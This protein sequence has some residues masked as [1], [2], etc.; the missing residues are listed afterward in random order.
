MTDGTHS[1]VGAAVSAPD[2]G[3]PRALLFHG[4]AGTPLEVAPVA[5]ALKAGGIAAHTPLLPGHGTTPEAYLASSFGEWR[6]F[7][8]A[9]YRRLVAEGPLLLGGY[10][11]GGILALDIAENAAEA[12]LPA[13]A[14]LL[15]LATPLWFGAWRP[16]LRLRGP[17]SW[18]FRLLPLTARLW[19]VLRVPPRSAEARSVAPWQGH[20]EVA[21]LR[22]FA[23][24]D[25][26]LKSIRRRLGLV[27]APLCVIQLRHD[28]SCPPGHAA[29]LLTHCVSAEA[30]LH[31]LRT[32]SPHGGHLPT[33]HAESRER[34][35]QLARA[36]A[37]RCLKTPD[38][39][40]L[41]NRAS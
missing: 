26:A 24:L 22:H 34:V 31:L 16:G 25:R 19:P 8:R 12:G 15:L 33:T 11:L 17:G 40:A 20:E 37:R 29:W 3:R 23:E 6:A 21:S 2:A 5:R 32:K 14:G 10:S 4:L 1:R 30:E 18:R 27:R 7:A 39:P 9:Q 36:F 13:P 41:R 28:A 35:A 38:F